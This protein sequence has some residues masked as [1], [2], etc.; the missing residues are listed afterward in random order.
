MLTGRLKGLLVDLVIWNEDHGGYRQALQNQILSLISPGRRRRC[1][2]QAR[3]NFL[4]GRQ[5]RFQNEDR[6]LFHTV[7]TD[8]DFRQFWFS[9]RT[10]Q[11]EGLR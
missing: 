3:R 6:V 8:R 7:S 1:Q 10:N 5:I 11:P 2:R 4:P 9:G